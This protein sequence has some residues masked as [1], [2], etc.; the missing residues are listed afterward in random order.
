MA[1]NISDEQEW[2]HIVNTVYS[3]VRN[4][5]NIAFDVLLSNALDVG[6]EY[7]VLVQTFNSINPITFRHQTIFMFL[8]IYFL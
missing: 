4:H 5:P 6:H 3:V 2:K 8:C 1:S 7:K